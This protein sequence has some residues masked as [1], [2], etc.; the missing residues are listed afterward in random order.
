MISRC[1]S[2]E[3]QCHFGQLPAARV[4]RS[5]FEYWTLKEAY[6][7]GIGRGLS[8]PL[9]AVHI[10]KDRQSEESGEWY[11]ATPHKGPPWQCLLLS[12]APGYAGGLAA[13]SIKS[14]P[15]FWRF[16]APIE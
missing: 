11:T 3:E 15:L 13:E 1:F 5:F 7:K 9:E 16:Q 8:Y 4:E 6:L 10:K 12:P 2:K 14:P